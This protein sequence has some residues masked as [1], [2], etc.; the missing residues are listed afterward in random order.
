MN[1]RRFL[2]TVTVLACL[3]LGTALVAAAQETKTYTVQPGDTLWSISERF[4]GDRELWP[5]LWEMN[6]Y[7]TTNPHQ[8]SVG[9]VLTIYPLETL[10]P[11]KEV[12][13]Q[14]VIKE[15]LYDPGTLLDVEYPRYFTFVADRNGIAGSGVS[16]V[17][18]KRF[19]P[20]TGK[21][22]ET[23]DE[24]R[25]VGEVIA[26]LER[27]YV[28]E[29]AGA[30]IHGRLLLSYYDDVIIRFTE[31]VAK[32]LDS[33]TH[34]DPDPY[35]REFPIYGFGDVIKEPDPNRHDFDAP[36]GQLHEFKGRLTVISRVET[37][38][39]MTDK[40]RKDLATQDGRNRD[41]EPVS[42]VAKI[43]YSTAPISIGDRIFLFKSLDPGPIRQTQKQKLHE[44]GEYTPT[45]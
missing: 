12:P 15:S 8:I 1:P 3:L 23:Y 31:D 44:S 27:G 26:S 29:D 34:E 39:P 32:I 28:E 36:L 18:V 6:R 4:Y 38:A 19:N 37:L 35:F 45:D 5:L 7:N 25:E 24:I 16:R 21:V 42:Y 41:S 17:K 10:Q 9:D 11:K 20:L 2:T 22:V 33:E 30:N 13:E 43:T 40:E 14:T